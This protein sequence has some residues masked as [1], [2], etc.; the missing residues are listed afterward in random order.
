ME[1]IKIEKKFSAGASSVS[2]CKQACAGGK[3]DEIELEAVVGNLA[4]VREFINSHLAKIDC[5]SKSGMHIDL[6]AEEIFVN[7]CNYAYAPGK[8]NV[9]V[10][11]SIIEDSK[12][13][14]TFVD[15][16]MQ[17]DPLANEDPDVT[18]S[19]EA[20]KIGGLGIFL[21]KKTMDSVSY[22]YKDGKNVLRMTKKL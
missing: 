17:Y 22:E 4:K 2:A 12:V 9:K 8:G 1:S 14:I 11:I 13:E 6:A 19:A 16:G 18:L 20:R 15:S 21:A 7:I 5:S 3:I 10:M